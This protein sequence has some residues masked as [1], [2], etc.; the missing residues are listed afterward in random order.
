[1]LWLVIAVAGAGLGGFS[2]SARNQ[3]MGSTGEGRD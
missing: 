2:Q 1:L 3:S